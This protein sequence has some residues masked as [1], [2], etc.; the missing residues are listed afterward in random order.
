MLWIVKKP[1]KKFQRYVIIFLWEVIYVHFYNWEITWLS[2]SCEWLDWIDHWNFTLDY[3]LFHIWYTH[4]T[5]MPNVQ[6]MSYSFVRLYLSKCDVCVLNH[7][8][9]NPKSFLIILY[10]FGSGFYHSLCSC[11]VLILFFIV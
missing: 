1:N 4:T 2:T 10:V 9:I 8:W 3:G 11:L 6:W 7:I 5:H